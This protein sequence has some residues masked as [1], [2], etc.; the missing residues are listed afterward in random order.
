MTREELLRRYAAGERDF[1]GADLRGANL[2][3]ADLRD[4]NLRWADLT[5][6]DLRGADL[7]DAD[8][9]RAN[10]RRANLRGADLRWAD[11][12]NAYLTGAIFARPADVDPRDLRLRVA[13][14]IEQHP[15]LHEQITWGDPHNCGTPA[16]VAGWTCRLAGVDY[17]D[18]TVASLAT[19]LLWVDG[20][21]MPSFDAD[22]TREEILAALRGEVTA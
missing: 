1:R 20:Q 5:D 8:L 15:E 17:T 16:C 14:Q 11:L 18:R 9:R 4:A 10:L 3:G 13:E 2:R 19:R 6:A 12:S 7:T 21:R 22:A